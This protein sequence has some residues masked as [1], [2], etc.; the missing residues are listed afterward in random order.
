VEDG[1]RKRG[2]LAGSGLRDPDHVAG[3]EDERDG[4]SLDRGGSY[5]LLV[6]ESPD[7]RGSEP[8]GIEVGQ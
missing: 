1:Q 8:E 5:V 6:Y 3:G 2:G 4:L 7:N